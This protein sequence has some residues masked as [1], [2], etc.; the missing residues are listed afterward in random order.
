[1]NSKSTGTASGGVPITN[2]LLNNVTGT[3][4]STAQ[5]IYILVANASSWDWTDV[6]I[7][8]STVSATCSGIPDGAGTSC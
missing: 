6:C 5:D 8:D 3:I 1:M 2:L 4:D 7:T